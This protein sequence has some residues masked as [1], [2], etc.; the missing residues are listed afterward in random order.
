[1]ENEDNHL[2]G[3]PSIQDYVQTNIITRSRRNTL[4]NIN[5]TSTFAMDDI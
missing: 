3:N 2:K 5:V 1:M 4:E